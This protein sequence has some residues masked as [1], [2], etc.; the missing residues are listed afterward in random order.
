MVIWG[1]TFVS[2]KVLVG[3]IHP[4]TLTTIRISLAAACLLGILAIFKKLRWLSFHEWKWVG[5]ASIFGVM[6]HHMFLSAGL[7][8]TTSVKGSIISGFSPLLTVLL[9]IIFG[10]AKLNFHTIFGV[11]LGTLGM[12]LAVS[13][14][15]RIDL[16]VNMGD[17][18]VFLSF[19]SQAI[20]FIIIRRLSN[21]LETIVI[22]CYMLCIGTLFLVPMSFLVMPSG[23]SVLLS[24][25]SWVLLLVAATSI[26]AISIGHTVYNLSIA[27]I[28]PAETAIIGNFNVIFALIFSFLLLKEPIQW[29][30]LVGMLLI[31]FGVLIATGVLGKL[32][33]KIMHKNIV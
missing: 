17:V 9:S 3:Y 4:V 33:K 15:Q 7:S 28:G 8:Q 27:K 26:L 19:L 2:I 5:I 12:I 29:I 18:F 24:V 31:I 14:G 6:L 21:G 32:F 23:Y 30:Q 22:T 1:A 10:Y 11:L 16:A 20:S 13:A 25:P